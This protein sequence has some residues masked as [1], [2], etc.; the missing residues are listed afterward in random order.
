MTNTQRVVL[1][2]ISVGIG[3]F[4]M[5]IANLLLPMWGQPLGPALQLPT[6]TH[7]PAATI[8]FPPTH[9]SEPVL[10]PGHPATGTPEPPTATP[11]SA[12]CGGP[13]TLM[14]LAI[15]S[16]QRID[17]YLYGLADVIRLVRVDFVTPSVSVMSFPR[18][19]YVEIPGISDHY[20]ITHGKVNQA[21]L[22]G[23]PGFGYYDGPDLGP[24][25]LAR[26]LYHNFGAEPER[27][28]AV[29]MRTFVHIVDAVGGINVTLEHT[30]DGRKEDQPD[31]M[32]LLFLSGT[33]HLNGSQ[34]LQLARLRPYGVFDR[35]KSQNQVLCGLYDEL[36]SPS[37]INHIPQII[38]AFE[39]NIQTDL[40]PAEISQLSCLLTTSKA[41]TFLFTTTQRHSLSESGSTTRS[42]AAPLSGIPTSRSSAPMWTPS[43]REPGLVPM[44][45]N[46]P[47]PKNPPPKPSAINHV[48]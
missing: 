44:N 33:H 38:G 43:H 6:N 9:T 7:A 47:S 10:E 32:D 40:S 20:G 3:I 34:A 14:I 15:G 35:G 30:V 4:C 48:P 21:D 39:D 23:K 1:F 36:L 16:D 13:D 27:Y 18:D 26:T 37:V 17:S 2:F 5:L 45:Q 46:L 8:D 42:S 41:A 25:L 31:R 24:G 12:L 11:R 19:L 28:L 29:N 22:Y